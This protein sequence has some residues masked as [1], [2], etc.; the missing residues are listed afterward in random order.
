MS[1]VAQ[2][3]DGLRRLR[4]GHTGGAC[5][6]ST[7]MSYVVGDCTVEVVR[8]D[9]TMVTVD[10]IVNAANEQ[11]NHGAGLAGAIVDAGLFR[12][13]YTLVCCCESATQSVA[14]SLS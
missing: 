14:K 13:K 11:L 5:D 1:S 7:G 4:V 12:N 10:A 6:D 3:D 2:V 9:L 8:G